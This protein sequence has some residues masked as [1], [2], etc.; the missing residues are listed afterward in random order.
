MRDVIVQVVLLGGCLFMLLAAIGVVRMPDL[1]MRI[2]AVTKSATM[3][4]G[5][6]L[7]A[8]VLREA[9]LD[10]VVKAF[11]VALFGFLT[12]PISGHMLSRAAYRRGV[13]LWDKTV[14]DELRREGT[15]HGQ[16]ASPPGHDGD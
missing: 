2:S 3:G 15:E 8:I 11:M 7:L 9:S 4:A 10:A 14:T 6:L 12:S 13:P 1:Y 16:P 5:L